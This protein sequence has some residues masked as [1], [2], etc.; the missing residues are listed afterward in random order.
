MACFDK[1]FLAYLHVVPFWLPIKVIYAVAVAVACLV[2]AVNALQTVAA[3]IA[4][5]IFIPAAKWPP[6]SFMK[7]SHE[8]SYLLVSNGEKL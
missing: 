2:N 4:A 7:L 3:L 5:K 1:S 8:A 6:L